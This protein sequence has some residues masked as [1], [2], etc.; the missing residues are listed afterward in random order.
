VL[1]SACEGEEPDDEHTAALVSPLQVRVAQTG[2]VGVTGTNWTVEPDGS[3]RVEK[4]IGD[5]RTLQREG[6]LTGAQMNFVADTLATA[7]LE[8]LPSSLGPAMPQ[9]NPRTISIS[10]GDSRVELVLP[11]GESLAGADRIQA[12]ADAVESVAAQA[13]E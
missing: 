1:C 11:G 2:V 9:A 7:R 10:T 4:F 3:Y 12:I 5:K 8:E 13:A 6:R